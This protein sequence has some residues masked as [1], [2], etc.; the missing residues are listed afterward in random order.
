MKYKNKSPY[1][2]ISEET[3]K[4]KTYAE[5]SAGQPQVRR[6]RP[7]TLNSQNQGQ[8]SNQRQL[9]TSTETQQQRQDQRQEGVPV[10][11]QPLPHRMPRNRR[12]TRLEG[13]RKL[14]PIQFQYIPETPNQNTT[15]TFDERGNENTQIT[16]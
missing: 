16:F 9:Q 6:Q 8:T 1:I 11:S 15:D 7:K 13:R 3:E 2:K 12:G 10:Q 14:S 4:K 5:V